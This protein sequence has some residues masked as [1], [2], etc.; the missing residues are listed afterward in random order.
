MTKMITVASVQSPVAVIS[1]AAANSTRTRGSRNG[2]TTRRHSGIWRGG[3]HVRAVGREPGA[4][5]AG[6]KSQGAASGLPG[7]RGCPIHLHRGR[8]HQPG[9]RWLRQHGHHYAGHKRAGHAHE[10]PRCRRILRLGA[11]N[12]RHD[13]GACHARPA[14]LHARP[15]RRV[16]AVVPVHQPR[17][18]PPASTEGPPAGGTGAVGHRCPR[19][20][21]HLPLPSPQNLG[22]HGSRAICK[23]LRHVRIRDLYRCR[24]GRGA[25]DP[26]GSRGPGPGPAG[27]D[28]PGQPGSSSHPASGIGRRADPTGRAAGPQRD[29][30]LLPTMNPYRSARVTPAACRC[31]PERLRLQY[32]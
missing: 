3:Q 16:P 24:T 28:G 6:D 7:A 10:H 15:A 4:A 14:R 21:G 31:I 18:C 5:S 26:D 19:L 27:Q 1:T 30:A 23:N 32:G 8:A 2:A 20:P 12:A 17:R 9:D 22:R 29:S 13:S 25:P 11:G